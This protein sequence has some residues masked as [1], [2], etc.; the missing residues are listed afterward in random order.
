[1]V[2]A[3]RRRLFVPKT[4]LSHKPICPF[5]FPVFFFMAVDFFSNAP[6]TGYKH[7]L[8]CPGVKEKALAFADSVDIYNTSG[9]G[10]F[11]RRF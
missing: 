5:C 3:Q 4:A 2:P 7:C 8:S 11:R 10:E 6:T 1:M 9:V